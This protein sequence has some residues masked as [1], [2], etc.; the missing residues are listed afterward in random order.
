MAISA[1]RFSTGQ[2][3]YTY[4]ATFS[5]GETVTRTSHRSYKYAV[6]LVNK[7]SGKL[8]NVTFTDSDT[9]RPNWSGIA[10]KVSQKYGMSSRDRDRHNLAVMTEREKWNAEVVKL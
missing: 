8:V 9:P 4:T 6:A 5:T 10:S 3:T 2:V 1:T 7:M